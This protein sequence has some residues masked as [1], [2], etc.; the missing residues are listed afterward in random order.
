MV[1]I[2]YICASAQIV[3]NKSLT[4]DQLV[5]TVLLG[6]DVTISNV[7]YTGSNVGIGS[8]SGTSNIGFSSGIVLASGD[9]DNCKGPNNSGS[10]SSNLSSGGDNDLAIIT[11]NTIFDASILEFDFSANT[12]TVTFE[13]TF[14]SEEYLEF[15]N[16]SF[17]DVFAFFI[18][19][20]GI[21]GTYTNNAMNI[22]LVP[23]TN[24]AVSINNVNTGSFPQYYVDNGD[25]HGGA[26][27]YTDS[28]TTQYDGITT[29]LT[30]TANITPCQTYHIKIAIADVGDGAYDSGVFLKAK[31]FSGQKSSTELTYAMG[32]SLIE[33]C[34]SG[35]LKINLPQAATSNYTVDLTYGG[36]A[37]NGT[38]IQLLPANVVIPTGQTSATLN[39]NALSDNSTEG[40][41]K[42]IIYAKTSLCQID[43]I[44]VN[45]SDNS[46]LTINNSTTIK[47]CDQNGTVTA[48]TSGGYGTMTYAWTPNLS[49]SS[50]L[51]FNVNTN[52][53]VSLTVTDQCNNTASKNFNAIIGPPDINAGNDTSI[54]SGNVLQI[55]ESAEAGYTYVWTTSSHL[56]ATNISNPKFQHSITGV[57]NQSFTQILK[58][59]KGTCL[60]ID[61]VVITVIAPPVISITPV[62]TLCFNECNGS[63]I[64]NTNA[65]GVTY[66]WKD[67]SGTNK[68]NGIQINNLCIGKY[69]LTITDQNGCSSTDSTTITQ[70]SVLSVQTTSTPTACSFNDGVVN[71]NPTGGTNPYSYSWTKSGSNEGLTKAVSGKG[72]GTYDVTVTDMNG[73]VTQANATIQYKTKPVITNLIATQPKCYQGN[74]GTISVA[75]QGANP[76]QYNWNQGGNLSTASALA[77][78][79]YSVIV[80]DSNGCVNDT[81]YTLS[82]PTELKIF[83]TSD[84]TICKNSCA[85]ITATASGGTGNITF[86]WQGIGTGATQQLCMD[87]SSVSYFVFASD[88]NQCASTTKSIVLNAPASPKVKLSYFP[89]KDIYCVNDPVT[90]SASASKGMAPYTY[91]WGHINDNINNTSA[92]LVSS[93]TFKIQVKDACNL[94][95][96]IDSVFLVVRNE[97]NFTYTIDALPGCSPQPVFL[98]NTSSESFTA[99]DWHLKNT[100][101]EFDFKSSGEAATVTILEGGIYAGEANVTTVEGCVYNI[102]LKDS[103]EVWYKARPNFVT[104][105][106]TILASNPIVNTLN[107]STNSVSYVWNFY[108]H[109]DVATY[110]DFKAT[111]TYSDT[112]WYK[113]Q[114]IAT[115]S[116]GCS[117]SITKKVYV[118]PDFTLYFPNAFTPDGNGNN[119]VFKGYGQFVGQYQLL[120]FDRWGELIFESNDLNV[121]WNGKMHNTGADCMNE[122]YVYISK[123]RE[124]DGRMHE[125]HGSVTLMR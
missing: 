42:L 63:A 124:L 102:P 8:F 80:S 118:I 46:P 50:T 44:E 9:I 18:S 122:V 120:I 69:Y 90:L 47:A 98:T 59:T 111:Y 68:G 11:S 3:T 49:S 27:S 6:S 116:Q 48:N 35:S 21:N 86:N 30:A 97:P 84:T 107:T 56:S 2:L 4:P 89:K 57:A 15:V 64:E 104:S 70:P 28:K 72:I 79:N 67:A 7:Q 60:N 110:T 82:Q 105:Q 88:A 92:N 62:A 25:G 106:T 74:D 61:T 22:A 14:G 85:N 76:F 5:R 13:Y 20:P 125:Q 43:T 87:T 37:V 103:V 41:E 66:L 96:N 51:N 78:G 26:P 16:S 94:L 121:G 29:V 32:T 65:A 55:G 40:A 115:S 113:I 71:A 99:I 52:P 24:T 123:A 23:G 112:G 83:L 1:N 58:K 19:G 117:D 53:N 34:M 81:S 100:L 33:G 108:D 93:T 36:T 31:S 39:L 114:L 73:C 109:D 45:I 95:S 17:N 119:E 91:Q 38:D 10:Q 101:G 12:P 54:C 77:A 75:V